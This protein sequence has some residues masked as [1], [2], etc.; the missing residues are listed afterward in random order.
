[1]TKP[2]LLIPCHLCGQDVDILDLPHAG[3]AYCEECVTRKQEEWER[4]HYIE[5]GEKVQ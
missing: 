2:K 1:M 3:P 5:L 4:Y